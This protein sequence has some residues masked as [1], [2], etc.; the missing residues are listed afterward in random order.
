MSSHLH[1]S[2]IRSIRQFWYKDV[3]KKPAEG[4]RKAS[5]LPIEVAAELATI[6]NKLIC[7]Q[8]LSSRAMLPKISEYD[9]RR[10][11]Y[12]QFNNTDVR[13]SNDEILG[14]LSGMDRYR[15]MDLDVLDME[16]ILLEMERTGALR[17]IAQ[18]FNTRYYRLWAPLNS[19]SCSSCSSV[20]HFSE[21]EENKHCLYCKA[22]YK[23]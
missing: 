18:N 13:F 11:I 17:P 3:Q 15:S 4:H 5:W 8:P 14:Y 9:V 22:P 10:I 7:W 20:S 6:N 21:A 2:Q 1:K 23:K 12:E 19:I 16:E